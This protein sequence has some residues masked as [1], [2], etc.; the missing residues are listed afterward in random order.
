MV[1]LV[2]EIM[3]IYRLVNDQLTKGLIK[4]W[5]SYLANYVFMGCLPKGVEKARLYFGNVLTLPLLE[6]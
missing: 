3:N 2:L 6:V 4:Q 1:M 5:K